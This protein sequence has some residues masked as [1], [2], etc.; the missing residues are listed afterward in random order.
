[1]STSAFTPGTAMRSPLPI[2]APA[3]RDELAPAEL[4]QLYDAVTSNINAQFEL[5]LTITFAVIVA[6]Y[7]AGHKLARSLQWLIAV[8][9]TAVSVLL[10]LM[11]LAAVEFGSRFDAIFFIADS[12]APTWTI[13]A[14]RTFIWILGTAATLTFVFKGH[15]SDGGGDT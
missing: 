14:L 4:I 2:A 10:F 11:L 5:W 9:Y 13:A 12:G 3:T 15:R 6:S 1:M 7:L 8:L